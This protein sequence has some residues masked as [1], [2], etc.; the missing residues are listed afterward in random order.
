MNLLW[1]ALGLGGQAVFAGR[2]W[3]QWIA[4]ERARK[5]VVPAA[6]WYMSLGGGLLLTAYFVWR[7]DL[8]GVIGQA[9]GVVIYVRNIRFL[10]LHCTPAAK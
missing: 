1:V 4:S 2:M 3:V 6:F 5:S 9:S 10:R 7:Q 8:V